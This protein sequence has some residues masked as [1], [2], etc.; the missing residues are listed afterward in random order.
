VIL[1][2]H[3][4]GGA[5]QEKEAYCG[6]MVAIIN[7]AM[8]DVR[9]VSISYLNNPRARDT[10]REDAMSWFHGPDFETY[11]LALEV[12]PQPIRERAADYYRQSI[13]DL[14]RPRGRPPKLIASPGLT[15]AARKPAIERKQP[16]ALKHRNAHP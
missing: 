13:P 7:R 11:C 8:M 15:R 1:F 5:I 6:L 9:G 12:D 14:K 16:Q 2:F 4:E 10:V 3:G